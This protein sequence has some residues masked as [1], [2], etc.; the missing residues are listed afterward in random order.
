M[1]GSSVVCAIAGPLAA[2]ALELAAQHPVRDR[3]NPRIRLTGILDL[4]GVVEEQ[5]A[6][7][8]DRVLDLLV[9]LPGVTG[10]PAA[11]AAP[12]RARPPAGSAANP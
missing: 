6:R 2:V 11:S 12:R 3:A 8:L 10:Q 4:P 5:R 7:G 9:S 1:T